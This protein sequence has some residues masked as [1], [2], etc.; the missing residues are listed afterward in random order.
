MYVKKHVAGNIYKHPNKYVS[1]KYFAL[2]E[3]LNTT[4]TFLLAS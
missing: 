1:S 2:L 4:K 3:V